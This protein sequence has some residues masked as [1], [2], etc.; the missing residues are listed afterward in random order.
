MQKIIST[1]SLALA[2]LTLSAC[3]QTPSK[4]AT[5]SNDTL[6]QI[7]QRVTG[8]DVHGPDIGSGEWFSMIERRLQLEGR[9]GLPAKGSANWC[10]VIEQT[11]R[12]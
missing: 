2:V 1:S 4:P 11:L 10:A 7:D 6:N 12:Q 8:G 5:C 3:G 9:P